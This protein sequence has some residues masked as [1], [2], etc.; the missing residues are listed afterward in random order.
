MPESEFSRDRER[1]SQNGAESLALKVGSKN[2]EEQFEQGAINLA[3]WFSR[4]MDL[5]RWS[6]PKLVS[7]ATT[8][9]GGKSWVH[10]SQI[11][12]L[13]VGRL[14]SPGPRSFAALV[15]M[16]NAIDQFQRGE[17]N[18]HSPDFTDVEVFIKNAVVMRDEDGEVVTLG[19]LFEVFCGWREPPPGVT[20]RD[21]S[22]AEA[23]YV[24]KSAGKHIRRMMQAER[25][26]LI[27]DMPALLKIF[28]GDKD[29]QKQLN[30]V[31]IGQGHWTPTDLEL[32]IQN[33]SHLMQRRFKDSRT[34]EEWL[35]DFLK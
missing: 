31:I 33:Y 20:K 18:E 3:K 25:L 29:V 23:L 5:N 26:E 10:S 14:K 4:I 16:F 12:A 11:A 34:P 28:S 9:T 22:E 13:R 8:A 2:I 1:N 27:D 6:H 19:Y 24:S 35:K 30:D 7:I 32:Q 15:Y 21:Y 17:Q